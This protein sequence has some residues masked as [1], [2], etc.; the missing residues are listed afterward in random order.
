MVALVTHGGLQRDGHR[1][2]GFRLAWTN[3]RELGS[4]ALVLAAPGPGGVVTPVRSTSL[5]FLKLS[6]RALRPPEATSNVSLGKR[7]LPSG[8]VADGAAGSRSGNVRWPARHLFLGQGGVDLLGQAVCPP[9][10]RVDE[11]AALPG[12]PGS[13]ELPRS[14]TSCR[15]REGQKVQA[16][17]RSESPRTGASAGPS[18]SSRRWPGTS[19]HIRRRSRTCYHPVRRAGT[20]AVPPS[21]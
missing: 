1:P 13:L 9:A 4:L 20:W 14:G 8:D 6:S 5:V 18:A 16:G 19:R 10:Q 7:V 17:Y 12:E 2:R 3:W 11:V 15:P 21:R